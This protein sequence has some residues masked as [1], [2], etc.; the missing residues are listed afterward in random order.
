M[1]DPLIMVM[2]KSTSM[3]LVNVLVRFNQL[4]WYFWSF[5]H[6]QYRHPPSHLPS[7]KKK[8]IYQRFR[9]QFFFILS[10]L[11][12]K[13]K[14]L[15]IFSLSCNYNND[16]T[17]NWPN[18]AF[19]TFQKNANQENCRQYSCI[20]FF[21]DKLEQRTWRRENLSLNLVFFT[22]WTIIIIGRL[23]SRRLRASSS[24]NDPV[25][26]QTASRANNVVCVSQKVL[27][28]SEKQ[29]SLPSWFSLPMWWNIQCVLLAWLIIRHP[30]YMAQK[31]QLAGSDIFY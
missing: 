19:F 24:H 3:N 26:I 18:S 4:L 25:P 2:I 14:S 1:Y 27:N 12:W 11:L 21:I 10:A 16:M 29:G 20:F 30:E 15:M 7:Q 28:V 23:Q 13:W 8:Y 17:Y 31:P 9:K 6:I 5:P 22:S